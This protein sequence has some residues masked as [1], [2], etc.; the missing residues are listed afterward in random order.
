[1]NDLKEIF[2]NR[3][4][5]TFVWIAIFIVLFSFKKEIRKSILQVIKSFFVTGIL[6]IILLLAIYTLGSILILKYYRFWD[7]ILIKD[8]IFWFVGFAFMTLFK[9][10][11]AKEISFFLN[12]LKDSFK[13]TIFLEFFLNFYT[14]SFIAEMIIIPVFTTIFLM[15]LVSEN[16]NEHKPVNKLTSKIIGIV[17]LIYFV[18][19]LYN[20][21][22]QNQN[23]FSNHNLNTL[24]LPVLLTILSIPFFYFTTLYSNY[25]RLFL[26]VKFM[27]ENVEIQ[28]K[29][30][31]QILWKAKLNLN[32]LSKLDNKLTGFNL[33]ELT[34][35]DE[36]TAGSSYNGFG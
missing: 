25:E 21:I 3:E 26:R 23:I 30:K 28:H 9:L 14:F 10:D 20:L 27:N 32:K 2:S 13:F 36:K 11:K 5:A 29:L 34:N 31:R 4:L 7:L 35:I 12:V 1:M 16:K 8:T 17:G 6:S 15:N 33:Y 19:A 24:I 18:F 22:F